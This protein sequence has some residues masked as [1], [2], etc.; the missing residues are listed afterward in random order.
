MWTLFVTLPSGLASRFLG[1]NR[2]PRRRSWG[3]IDTLGEGRAAQ[4]ERRR[5]LGAEQPATREGLLVSLGGHVGS[6][7]TQ[8][9]GC[10]LASELAE[11]AAFV[12]L[13]ERSV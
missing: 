5:V 4:G 12:Q 7:R 10:T 13:M 11:Q 8:A 6:R 1:P 2:H 3:P 9:L